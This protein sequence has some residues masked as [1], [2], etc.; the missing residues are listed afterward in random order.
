MTRVAKRLEHLLNKDTALLALGA[1][2]FRSRLVRLATHFRNGL[3]GLSIPFGEPCV[4]RGDL[5]LSPLSPISP[6]IS[7]LMNVPCGSATRTECIVSRDL[8]HGAWKQFR[9]GGNSFGGGNGADIEVSRVLS[10]PGAGSI[11]APRWCSGDVDLLLHRLRRR[12]SALA[13]H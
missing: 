9:S 8:R 11:Y 6:R 3:L 4:L 13:G 10:G 5:T 12:G 7:T 2:A 1:A